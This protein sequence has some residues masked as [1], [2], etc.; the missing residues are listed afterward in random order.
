MV[1]GP[2]LLGV[3]HL[4]CKEGGGLVEVGGGVGLG[5]DFYLTSDGLAWVSSLLVIVWIGKEILCGKFGG[6]FLLEIGNT[7]IIQFRFSDRTVLIL[8]GDSEEE[9]RFGNIKI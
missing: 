9:W 7:R 6:G 1:G 5:G 4:I 3:V 2:G 8:D